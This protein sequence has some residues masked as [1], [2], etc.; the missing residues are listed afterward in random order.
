MPHKE[1]LRSAM[2]VPR[3]PELKKTVSTLEKRVAELESKLNQIN[4]ES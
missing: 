1:W 3:L 4:Q 2:V